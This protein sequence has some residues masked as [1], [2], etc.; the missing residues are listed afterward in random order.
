MD[1]ENYYL[2][3]MPGYMPALRESDLLAAGKEYFPGIDM[4]DL[5][6]GDLSY[7]VFPIQ[8]EDDEGEAACRWGFLGETILVSESQITFRFVNAHAVVGTED[9]GKGGVEHY[10][11]NLPMSV[12]SVKKAEHASLV[13]NRP[14]NG[15]E[16]EGALGKIPSWI[17]LS[18]GSDQ[19]KWRARCAILRSVMPKAA[20]TARA[21]VLSDSEAKELINE[22][23]AAANDRAEAAAVAEKSDK[24]D[25]INMGT[26]VNSK[27]IVEA[28]S[29]LSSIMN[30]TGK[31]SPETSALNEKVTEV[32]SLVKAL[33]LNKNTVH[34]QEPKKPI[35]TTGVMISMKKDGKCCYQVCGAALLMQSGASPSKIGKENQKMVQ[36]AKQNI[37]QNVCSMID[38][39][40]EFV[41]AESDDE[42][43]KKVEQEWE[44]VLSE[45]P[46][47]LLS[48]VVEGKKWGGIVEL[49]ASMWH[50]DTEVIV[51][52][53][54]SIHAKASDSDVVAGVHR[55]MLEGLPAGPA[56]KK[57]VF[58][59][60]K[61]HHYYFG[62]TS[63]GGV[64]RAIF[65]VGTDAEEA[66]ARI[67]EFLKT[68]NKGPL[69]SLSSVERAAHI[70]NV[71]AEQRKT[72]KKKVDPNPHKPDM[73]GKPIPKVTYAD[74]AGR[75]GRE[76][77]RSDQAGSRGSSRA[78]SR[79]SDKKSRP[80]QHT[81][82]TR[83]SCFQWDAKGSCS[84]GKKCHFEHVTKPGVES[85][86]NA[87]QSKKSTEQS[88]WQ[89]AGGNRRRKPTDRYCPVLKVHSTANL[90]PG[91]WRNELKSL[92]EE[93]HT[94][95]EWV[96]RE[97]NWFILHADPADVDE[98]MT[99]L[100]PL[101]KLGLTVDVVC[102]PS[103]A[104]VCADYMAGRE[105]RHK[106]PCK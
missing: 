83:A 100:K 63:K 106:S 55:A 41:I 67:I 56:K 80:Q 69:E 43:I 9:K 57:R 20:C 30:C 66:Q 87:R 36:D 39:H 44:N 15:E 60:L 22:A 11:R 81:K 3:V 14:P 32:L 71:F 61:H 49:G 91:R 73:K 88:E 24:P 28:V 59:V 1:I 33:V 31:V 7:V 72:E 97:E 103:G 27:I 65:D 68:E 70:A 2:P 54:E 42:R 18:T 98:L 77:E 38:M 5:K 86:K 17:R 90:H 46:E 48:S 82:K 23:V 8:D 101:R 84:Y 75:R 95:T 4:K 50:T 16:I 26:I 51:L 74:A 13:P 76:R 89:V 19:E 21:G 6:T 10:E 93:T 104:S 25:P 29:E 92:H 99:S 85:K 37:V 78:R 62:Y 52:H 96:S 47:A 34:H 12:F 40:K 45:S 53:A 105:C 94:L 58:V 79:S 102:E 64:T 35:E